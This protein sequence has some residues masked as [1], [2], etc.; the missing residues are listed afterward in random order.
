MT[1]GARG[2]GA[3]LAFILAAAVASCT[4]GG[5]AR[6]GGAPGQP[7]QVAGTDTERDSGSTPGSGSQITLQD[8]D[9]RT[10]VLPHPA[11]RIVSLVPSA[12]LT[13]AALGAQDRVV[14][15]TDHDT[16]SWARALPSVGGGLNPSME[17]VVAAEPD[18]VIRFGGPQD[19]RTPASLDDLGIRQ[20]AIRP[21]GVTDVLAIVRMLGQATDHV[22]DAQA[23][24]R[25]ISA[26]LDSVRSLAAGLPPVR[27]A[28]VLGG[29]PP[30]VAGPGTYIH[31]LLA[32][33]G[34]TNVFEDLDKLYTSVSL[35][36]FLARPVD[37]VLTPNAGTLDPRIAQQARVVEV[38]DAVELPGPAVADAALSLFHALHPE[39]AR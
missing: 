35:E 34:G 13:L 10:V 2:A 28:Y 33:A 36:E 29:D 21:D 11:R 5:D 8:S 19:T 12:T 26:R 14:A 9:G 37:L 38:T 7:G 18:L 20:L 15:R 25:S 32:L 24:V 3:A 23:L 39:A 4:A 17:A 16:V 31:E 1:P 22:E 27:V 6:G 30:W